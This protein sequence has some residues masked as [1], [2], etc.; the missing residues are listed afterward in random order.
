MERNDAHRH[1]ESLQYIVGYAGNQQKDNYEQVLL[2]ILE[3][4][5]LA[6][7]CRQLDRGPAPPTSASVGLA[8]ALGANLP[9]NAPIATRA[10]ILGS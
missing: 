9:T 5:T 6:N 10:H 4:K 1:T 8:A 7:H 3:K 2:T